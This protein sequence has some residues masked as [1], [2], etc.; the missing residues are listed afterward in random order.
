MVVLVPF[1]LITAVFSQITVLQLNLPGAGAANNPNRKTFEVEVVVRRNRMDLNDGNRL[2]KRFENRD[3]EY[4]VRGLSKTLIAVKQK[5]PD[6]RNA[7]IL[8]EPD[9]EYDVLVRIMDGVGSAEVVQGLSVEKVQLFPEISIGDA[10][11]GKG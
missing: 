5:Y 2:I 11:G 3:G 1:L 6:K 7:T 4:D 8:L 10:P 9:I